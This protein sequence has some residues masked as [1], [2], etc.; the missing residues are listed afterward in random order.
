MATTKLFNCLNFLIKTDT[1]LLF[2]CI[3]TIVL[4]QTNVYMQFNSSAMVLHRLYTTTTHRL[5]ACSKG[6]EDKEIH[7]HFT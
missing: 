3:K 5:L 7:M 2:L 1:A 4:K 6:R